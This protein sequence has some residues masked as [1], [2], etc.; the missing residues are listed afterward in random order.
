MDVEFANNEEETKEDDLD[1]VYVNHEKEQHEEMDEEMQEGEEYLN[2][3]FDPVD[4]ADLP[5]K[6]EVRRLKQEFDENSKSVENLIRIAKDSK[7]EKNLLQTIQ[8]QLTDRKGR[9]SVRGE[10]RAAGSQV[11]LVASS[12]TSKFSIS[13][14]VPII[15][16]VPSVRQNC[17]YSGEIAY[18]DGIPTEN[19]RGESVSYFYRRLKK[20]EVNK[21]ENSSKL[22]GPIEIGNKDFIKQWRQL[23]KQE[24]EAKL[25][26]AEAAAAEAGAAMEEE[27]KD[28]DKE[29]FI[30]KLREGGEA[31][32]QI[33][34]GIASRK[35]ELASFTQNLGRKISRL[36]KDAS[37]F[38]EE[39]PKTSFIDDQAF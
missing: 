18:Y 13:D 14:N 11:E 21:D 29:G 39:A 5:T 9:E 30:S 25:A 8:I 28:V 32:D 12:T 23:Q 37:K 34:F 22:E 35:R 20:E 33:S 24:S 36:Q 15:P 7:L 4:P 6:D 31:G 17:L 3:V 16:R 27:G 38:T 19:P 10:M 1:S 2:Q 26:A